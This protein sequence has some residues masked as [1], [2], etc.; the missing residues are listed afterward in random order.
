MINLVPLV[1]V[2]TALYQTLAKYITGYKVV[3]DTT[4]VEDGEPPEEAVIVIGES[5]AKPNTAK[6]DYPAWEVTFSIH[7]FSPYQGKAQLNEMFNDVVC[8]LTGAVCIGGFTI[9]GYELH[10]LEID[11]IEAFREEYTD[12]EVWQHGIVRVL[13]KV[14]PKEM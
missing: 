7:C 6:A 10:D 13:L 12:G 14:E 11:M 2:Q 1:A 9:K 8:T 3:D 5:T 4:P